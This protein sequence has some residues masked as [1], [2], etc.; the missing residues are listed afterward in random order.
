MANILTDRSKQ[1]QFLKT[2]IHGLGVSRLQLLRSEFQ[3]EED[4]SRRQDLALYAH[5]LVDGYLI[6]RDDYDNAFNTSN[7]SPQTVDELKQRRER[8]NLFQQNPE[9]DSAQ[10]TT[11]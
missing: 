5:D 3:K 6:T 7:L 11:A 9:V 4:N 2:I 8:Y 10:R 1:N